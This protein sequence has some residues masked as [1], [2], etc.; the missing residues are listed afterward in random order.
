MTSSVSLRKLPNLGFVLKL[1]LFKYTEA[2]ADRIYAV[3]HYS[4]L[5]VKLNDLLHSPEVLYSTDY[6][7]SW[8]SSLSYNNTVTL[9]VVTQ[10]LRG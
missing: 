1:K 7:L 4:R 2:I 10:E 5:I 9:T 3:L 8:L 6:I